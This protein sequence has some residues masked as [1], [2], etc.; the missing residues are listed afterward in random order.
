MSFVRMN[1]FC[2]D[3]QKIGTVATLEGIVAA[4]V[5]P[6]RMTEGGD[7][8]Y[9]KHDDRKDHQAAGKETSNEKKGT[10]HHQMIPVENTAGGAAAVLHDKVPERTPKQNTDQVANIEKSCYPK[11]TKITEN[12]FCMQQTERRGQRTPQNED[13]I[14]TFGCCFQSYGKFTDGQGIFCF[15]EVNTKRLLG[16]QRSNNLSGRNKLGQHIT[17]P[18]NP[19]KMEQGGFGKEAARIEWL[20]LSG[21]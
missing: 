13:H 21:G 3:T 12:A 10:E 18:Y 15:A 16:A 7:F 17:D 8:P 14:C 5:K 6:L 19:Q 4:L 9:C 2:I 20:K 1:L 11:Q